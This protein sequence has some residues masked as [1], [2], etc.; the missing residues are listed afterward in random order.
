[1]STLPIWWLSF[2]DRTRPR[3]FLGA[4]VTR[5]ADFGAALDDA[6]ARG[7]NPGG[8]VRGYPMADLPAG[9]PTGRLLTRAEAEEWGEHVSK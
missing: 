1:M 4:Y 8:E 7:C 9:L 3:G 6:T 2:S 5:A